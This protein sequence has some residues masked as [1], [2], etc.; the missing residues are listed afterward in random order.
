MS[1]GV[2]VKERALCTVVGRLCRWVCIATSDFPSCRTALLLIRRLPTPL[3]DFSSRVAFVPKEWGAVT[4]G[5]CVFPK[6]II[7]YGH[8]V[9]KLFHQSTLVAGDGVVPWARFYNRA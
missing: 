7:R 5:W 4:R 8:R 3:N 6:E 1:F 2:Q 9:F